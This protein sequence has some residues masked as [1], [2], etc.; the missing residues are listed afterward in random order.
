VS[1]FKV[2]VIIPVYN[3]EKYLK[4]AIESALSQNETGEVVVVEDKSPDN[5]LKI[6]KQMSSNDSRISVYQHLDKQNHGAGASRN[7]GIIKAKFDYISF[8]DADDYYLP[9]RFK[10]DKHLFDKDEYIDGV[11]NALGTD[12]YEE[13]GN[14]MIPQKFITTIRKEVDPEDLFFELVNTKNGWI[15][16]NAITV[17][18]HVFEKAGVF[19]HTLE[20]GEDSDLWIR[21]SATCKLVGGEIHEPVAM[22]GVHLQNRINDVKRV[23]HYRPILFSKLLNWAVEKKLPMDKT[24]ILWKSYY[25][26][27]IDHIKRGIIRRFADAI[28]QGYRYPFLLGYSEY[29]KTFPFISRFIS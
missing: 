14:A 15:H 28:I 8:L 21:V 17:K 2:S 24:R 23:H 12:Y 19:D 26:T 25:Q 9:N 18:K 5:S 11:Y 22:R 3:A 10:M 4:K 1:E 16:S 27:N 6:A 13:V 7:L 20:I 29:Y